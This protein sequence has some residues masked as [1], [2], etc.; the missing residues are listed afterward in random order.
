M[1][2]VFYLV[3]ALSPLVGMVL[4]RQA[5][6]DDDRDLLLGALIVQGVLAIPMAVAYVTAGV[7]V[8]IWT[9]RARKN[10]DAFP[11]ALPTLGA[12]WAIAGWLVP[13]A[14]L[15]VPAR[16]VANVARDSLWRRFT[17]A[18]VA[19]WW[20][21]WLVFSVGE[22]MVDLLDRRAY[23][24]LPEI[25][26]TDGGYQAYVDYYRD[27]M[28]RNAVPAVACVIA[29]VTLI[30]LI[31]RISAAQEA[32]IARALPAWPTAP[33]WPPA[34]VSPVAQVSTAVHVSAVAQP[35]P[36]VQV[37]P[38][39]QPGPVSPPGPPEAGGTIGA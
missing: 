19:V 7:L 26:F 4:A 34:Q 9:W 25:P 22:R 27:S 10:T 8:I 32:R 15:A 1:T 31:Q 12:G 33:V 18:L 35:G 11:G 16:V 30:M 36:V 6:A 2:A 21:A 14:N 37:S 17:P 23:E 29:A 5:R 38:A 20:S 13:F 3:V 39:A 28:L 24:R